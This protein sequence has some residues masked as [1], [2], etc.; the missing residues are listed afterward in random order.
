MIRCLY[1]NK[2]WVSRL[3]PVLAAAFTFAVFLPALRNGFVNWDDVSNLLQNP[4]YMGLG[5]EQFKWMFTTFHMGLYQ[6]LSWMTLGLDYLIWGMNPFGYHLTSVFLHCANALIFY[7]LCVRLLALSVRPARRE[8]ETEFYLSAGFAAVLFAIHPLRVESVAWVTERRDVLSG[9]FYLL[10]IFWY[11]AARS[12][13]GEKY[14]FWRRHILPLTAFFLSLLSKGITISLPV[15][16]IVLDI[17]PL[18]RLPGSPGRWFSPEVREIWLEKIPFFILAAGFG[19][20]GCMGQAE[21]GALAAYQQFGFGPR[22]AQALFSVW[23]YIWKT[24]IP[25]SLAPFYRL[26]GDFNL[27]NW[28]VMSAGAVIAA[29]TAV[30]IAARRRWPAGLAVWAYYL[31]TLSPV[32]GIVKFGSQS[33]A[34]RYTYL[35]CLGFAALA[36]AGFWKTRQT[37]SKPLKNLCSIFA[38]LIISGLVC[39]TWRQEKIWR[40][41]ETL[42]THALAIDPKLDLAHNNLGLVMISRGELSLAVRYFQEAIRLNPASANAYN[43][44]GIV[45]NHQGKPEE[46]IRQY[47]EALKI[48]PEDA[49]VRY[50]LACALA[51]RGKAKMPPALTSATHQK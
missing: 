14:T 22:A 21:I 40:D 9:L 41:S 23:F 33:V 26:P 6:P 38:C 5:R 11:I 30:L 12:A 8:S 35:P 2:K 1:I 51:G 37:S 44:L 18:R 27:L 34:D 49:E 4:N 3:M 20:I 36:G 32:A 42:W 28:Q 16:L 24:M 15:A 50:N 48:S 45:L 13:G 29:I 43:N 31:V 19:V 7:L 39:L 25:V 47:L 17:Y 46:A 10:T